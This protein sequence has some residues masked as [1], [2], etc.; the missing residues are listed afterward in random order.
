MNGFVFK[1][2]KQAFSLVEMMFSFAIFAIAAASSFACFGSGTLLLENARHNTRS[3]QIMQNEIERIRALPWEEVIQLKDGE[4]NLTD[5]LNL[6][7]DDDILRRYTQTYTLKREM[8]PYPV[9]DQVS[10]IK[11]TLS[12]EWKD[13]SGRDHKRTYITQYTDGGLYDNISTT[14]PK[15]S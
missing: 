15:T 9:N 14:D 10:T 6:D 1:S 4:V 2:S 3:C 13:F 5:N 12:I 7:L 8:N 11:I